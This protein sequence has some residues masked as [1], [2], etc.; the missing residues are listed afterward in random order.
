[1]RTDR[2]QREHEVQFKWSVFPLHPETPEA[3]VE[4]A[5]LFAGR[6]LDITA[7]QQRVAAVADGLGLPLKPRSRTFN[8]RAAQELGKLAQKM[9]LMDAYQKCVY[10]A[11]FVDGIN[12]AVSE[13]LLKIARSAGLPEEESRQALEEKRFAGE[14]DQ[15]WR[16]ARLLGITGV[17]AFL[18][19][20]RLLVGFRP[21]QDFVD[22][23][24]PE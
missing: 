18:C 1:M 4:L 2:L 20:G 13:E 11:Y 19:A 24:K 14:V 16:R 3:G 15:D 17:P 10:Q 12:I 9:G 7:M 8:S 21:Y 23:I 22:L 5:D 6:D